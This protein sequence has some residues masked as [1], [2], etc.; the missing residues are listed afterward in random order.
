M[1]LMNLRT[2]FHTITAFCMVA[3]R[4][5]IGAFLMG[6]VLL[7]IMPTKALGIWTALNFA[8]I[9][10][11]ING[12]LN[13]NDELKERRH[14][15]FNRPTCKSCGHMDVDH[16]CGEGFCAADNYDCECKSFKLRKGNYYDSQY[17]GSSGKNQSS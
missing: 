14:Y 16:Y 12:I 5:S 2:I 1:S 15:S 17:K 13:D 9:I 3:L 11:G 8:I 10:M 4:F 6:L 7:F